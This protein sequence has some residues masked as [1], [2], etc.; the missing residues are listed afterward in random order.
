[1]LLVNL[2]KRI[3]FSQ[4]LPPS[5]VLC[6]WWLNKHKQGNFLLLHIWC[7]FALNLG[8]S[9]DCELRAEVCLNFNSFFTW[10]K[11]S[12]RHTLALVRANPDTDLWPLA[13]MQQCFITRL[14]HFYAVQRLTL[15]RFQP[16]FDLTVSLVDRSSL[17]DTKT[18][19]NVH[20]QRIMILVIVTIMNI[21]KLTGSNFL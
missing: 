8:L 5:S 19:L 14:L 4:S 9:A 15:D 7:S 12:S 6:G 18:H 20:I 1:M 11:T 21:L 3:F 10:T 2:P 16:Q 17:S 13:Q